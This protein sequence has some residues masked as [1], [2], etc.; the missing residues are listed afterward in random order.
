[1][2]MAK[3]QAEEAQ[4][5]LLIKDEQA[6]SEKTIFERTTDMFKKAKEEEAHKLIEQ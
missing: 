2:L 6:E 5:E 4:T 1:M 3:A